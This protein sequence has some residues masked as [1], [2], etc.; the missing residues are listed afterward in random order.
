MGVEGNEGEE[1]QGTD[2]QAVLSTEGKSAIWDNGEENSIGDNG[3][4]MKGLTRTCK[5]CGA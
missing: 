1:R 2:N 5:A 4:D 3:E